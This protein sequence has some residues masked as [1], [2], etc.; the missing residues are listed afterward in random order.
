MPDTIVID[1][2]EAP[3]PEGDGELLAAFAR[4]LP[5]LAPGI[6]LPTRELLH[7]LLGAPG[8]TLLLARDRAQ[9]GRIVGICTLM[10]QRI[11]SGV[12]ATIEDVVVDEGARGRGIGAALTREALRLARALGARDVDLTSSP[13]REAANRLYLRLGFTRRETNVYRYDLARDD[14]T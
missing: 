14:T 2:A 9:C 5:Q 11:P 6:A 13:S 7:E 1:T 3:G 4:L 10:R 12:R 8:T